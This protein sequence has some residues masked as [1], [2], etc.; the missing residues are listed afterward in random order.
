MFM[1]CSITLY[2]APIDV[3]IVI[4]MMVKSNVQHNHVQYYDVVLVRFFKHWL[5][6]A[7]LYVFQQEVCIYVAMLISYKCP[8]YFVL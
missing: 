1:F 2:G 4:V 6:S 3:H 7:A 5:T 8:Y